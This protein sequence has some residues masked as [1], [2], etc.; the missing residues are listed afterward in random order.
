[1]SVTV[2]EKYNAPNLYLSKVTITNRS[3]KD[4]ESIIFTVYVNS[5]ICHLLTETAILKGSVAPVL[6]SL[7]YKGKIDIHDN[8]DEDQRQSKNDYWKTRR[9]YQLPTLNRGASLEITYLVDVA[10][11]ENPWIYVDTNALGVKIK[12]KQDPFVA[13]HIWGIHIRHAA[14]AGI[15]FSL[16]F[17][18][19]VLISLGSIF[20]PH[21]MLALLIGIF[22]AAP[23]A[24]ILKAYNYLR[25]L[26]AG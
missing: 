25:S 13:T 5:K 10:N 6:Y 11:G 8:D 23:G 16:L 26:I 7:E 4:I 3:L 20:W 1:M 9:E 18:F 12:H 14:Y 17:A 2:G 19:P 22:C 21:V 15:L 24:W